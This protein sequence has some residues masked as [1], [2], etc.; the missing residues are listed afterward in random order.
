MSPAEWNKKLAGL[1]AAKHKG[2][3]PIVFLCGPKSSGKSTFGKLL[4]NRFITDQGNV[5]NKP[6]STVAVLDIDP[7]QPEFTPPGLVSLNKTTCPNLG[8]TFCHPALE[9]E[10]EQ[11]RV[12]AIASTTPGQN[13]SHYVEAVLDLFSLYQSTL[14]SRCP[15]IINTAGWIQ[16]TG[17]DIL[18]E[19]IQK[20]HP[21][22]VIYMS[23][24]GP[25]ETVDDLKSACGSAISFSILPSQTGS[26]S[27]RTA[28]DFRTM[29][30]M[31]YFHLHWPSLSSGLP[32]WDPAPLF[33]MRQWRV[34][35]HTSSR[36]FLGILCYGSQP[37][38]ELLDERINGMI[39]A[40]VKIEDQAALSDLLPSPDAPEME[41]DRLEDEHQQ[42]YTSKQR[43]GIILTPQGL[44]L[45][46]NPNDR[47]LS[48]AHS[49]TLGLVLIQGIDA[50]EGELQLLSPLPEEVL[51]AAGEDAKSL[52]LVVGGFDTP[53]WSYTED[54]YLKTA[55]GGVNSGRIATRGTSVEQCGRPY[56]E[57][58]RGGEKKSAGSKGWRVRRDLG[59]RS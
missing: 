19:L 36:G 15:L 39:L 9:F 48:P 50:T 38:P 32:T 54:L 58:L 10:K 51:T 20:L 57:V 59:R 26:G 25:E 27:S 30:T 31:S 12:H 46:L 23:Q 17:L 37:A 1:A 40:L 47:A 33:T 42:H 24:D 53:E 7:G 43:C 29:Q 16:G 3:M 52:V 41:L 8:P 14:S 55:D 45:I 49:R 18:S 22:E 28:A 34:Q 44:P 13:P 6:W 35:Y 2:A 4:L 56:V 5:N 21:S 11:L